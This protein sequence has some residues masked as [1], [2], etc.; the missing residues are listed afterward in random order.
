MALISSWNCIMHIDRKRIGQ[1]LLLVVA[2]VVL[3][4]LASHYGV[5][6]RNKENDFSEKE[7]DFNEIVLESKE[8]PDIQI[9]HE[10]EVV[11]PGI[12]GEYEFL[13]LADL[14]L[15]LNTRGDAGV[16]GDAE[17]RINYF[18]NAKGTPSAEHLPQWVDYANQRGVD[19]VLMDGD[20]IDYY[21][22]EIA[23]YLCENVSELEVPYLF[24]LGN[25]E[26]F[27]PW[28]EAIPEDSMIYD[29]FQNGNTT[30]QMLDFGE[31]VICAIDNN[32][33]QVD[34]ASLAA[35]KEAIAANP[36]KPMILL[37]H[38]PF[39]T[40]YDKELLQQ[41]KDTWNQAL[42]IGTGEGTRDTTSVSREFL[43]LI[44]G[45]DSPVVAIFTGDN[46]FYHKGNLN[47][48]VTQW[49]VAPAFAGDGMIIKVK[50]S[51]S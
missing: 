26:L 16:Y 18:S 43:D 37:A 48:Q 45:E 2:T 39:Y 33:Y 46:H 5:A 17:E 24:T 1:V 29:L 3:V 50:G 41:S 9:S 25:H 15:A 4:V 20:I 8:F 19:A 11:I 35:M 10:E 47:E 23:A 42:V 38:V 44:L 30:F 7:N 31:F 6:D 21:S 22:D 32:S 51:E 36:D 49:V 27:S 34:P 40:E 12:E 13:I 28:S 14:H